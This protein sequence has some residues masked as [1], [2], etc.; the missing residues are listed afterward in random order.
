MASRVS[1]GNQTITAFT[2]WLASSAL[3][4][5]PLFLNGSP[6]LFYDSVAYLQF[7]QKIWSFVVGVSTSQETAAAATA[8]LSA[9]PLES[10]ELD[11]LLMGGRSYFYSLFIWLAN[12]AGGYS[13][14]AIAQALWIAMALQLTFRALGIAD[15]IWRLSGV[16]LLSLATPLAL[17]VCTVMPDVFAAVAPL[18]VIVL[19]SRGQRM[20]WPEK[21]FW[22]FS[23]FFAVLFH[24]AFLLL[25]LVT[26]AFTYVVVIWR[27]WATGQRALLI[28]ATIG[29]G[30]SA[31]VMVQQAAQ[32][33][34][35]K[36]LVS[37]PFLLA[38][39]IGDGT[40]PLVLQRDCPG[41]ALP[42]WAACAFLSEL[43]MTENE[44]IWGAGGWTSLPPT[45]RIAVVDEQ[46]VLLGT[47]AAN[48]PLLQ[49]R[50]SLYNFTTQIVTSDVTELAQSG[51]PGMITSEGPNAAGNAAYANSALMQG[52]FPLSALSAFWQ[53]LYLIATSASLAILARGRPSF[54][55]RL[56]G[57]APMLGLIL[58][59][60]LASAAITGIIAGPFGRYQARIAWL[61]MLVLF[62]L[63]THYRTQI[64]EH[65]QRPD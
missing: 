33:A 48:A 21:A 17:F 42:P 9:S 52:Q 40:I 26:L 50:A 35:G 41:A 14:I 16:A 20:A 53:A 2:F 23:L 3:L 62:T 38:R 4:L 12:V 15:P 1:S 29:F 18:A 44:A 51:I 54:A 43:P 60:L 46:L 56:P 65:R 36:Q 55:N 58:A 11:T 8:P 32:S 57:L 19:L 37:P 30:I 7:G 10:A 27:K 63:G 34:T 13:T 64:V 6:F 22:L 39:G 25:A 47:A 5:W 31:E 61:S 49:I 28:L 59:S 45:I 24:K